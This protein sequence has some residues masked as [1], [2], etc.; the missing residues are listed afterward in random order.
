M[1]LYADEAAAEV[2]RSIDVMVVARLARVEVAAALARKHRMGELEAEALEVLLNEFE[3]DWFAGPGARLVVV[4][5][6]DDVLERAAGLAVRPGLRAF[7]AVQ[8]ASATAAR[9]ADPSCTTFACFD[10]ALR[11]AAEAVG[12]S[13]QPP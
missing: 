4:E 10:L 3:A 11:R 8:L 12:F 13:L 2:V 7:D 6:T 1:K 9:Q 5:D